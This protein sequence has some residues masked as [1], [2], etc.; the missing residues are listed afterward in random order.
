MSEINKLFKPLMLYDGECDFCRKWIQ[1]WRK[2][3]GRFID[4]APYQEVQK[5]FPQVS[6]EACQKAVQLIMPDGSVTS[7]AHAVFKAMSLA[8]G[9]YRLFYGLYN[10]LPF[11][12]RVS[13]IIYQWVAH[14]RVFLSKFTK[15]GR[16][17]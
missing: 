9:F 10:Y 15:R 12:D 2:K 4:Y 3:S 6:L 8:G 14:H 17:S 5:N 16:Y 13:E 7:G 1:R 11:F